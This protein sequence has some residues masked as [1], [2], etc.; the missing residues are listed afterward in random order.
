MSDKY[1]KDT[2][3]IKKE[4]EKNLTLTMAGFSKWTSLN[5]GIRTQGKHV[6]C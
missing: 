2:L 3:A 4:K 6:D 1:H 5:Y